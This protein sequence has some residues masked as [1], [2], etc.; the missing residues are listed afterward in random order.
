MEANTKILTILTFMV[1]II[2]L[3][4]I[5]GVLYNGALT[6]SQADRIISISQN[7]L[8]AMISKYNSLPLPYTETTL[9]II[10][11]KTGSE[12]GEYK[13]VKVKSQFKLS[14]VKESTIQE[15]SDGTL[16]ELIAWKNE[17]TEDFMIAYYSALGTNN[18]DKIEGVHDVLI[19][20]ATR[21][22]TLQRYADDHRNDFVNITISLIIVFGIPSLVLIMLSRKRST[23]AGELKNVN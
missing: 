22:I 21:E 11:M 18:P 10:D 6:S 12:T 7:D 15:F 8:E 1:G 13:T 23:G 14:E 19:S 5:S 16:G 2:F 20:A 17:G 3:Q 4:N 9:P